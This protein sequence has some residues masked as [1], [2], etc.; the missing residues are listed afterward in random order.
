MYSSFTCFSDLSYE[1]NLFSFA[2]NTSNTHS[3]KPCNVNLEFSFYF[4]FN[5]HDLATRIHSHI[6]AHQILSWS[7][8]RN[9]LARFWPRSVLVSRFLKPWKIPNQYALQQVHSVVRRY[10]FLCNTISETHCLPNLL[11]SICSYYG[12]CVYLDCR[13]SHF[14]LK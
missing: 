8:A 2:T 13:F 7:L 10:S 9:G 6:Y 3:I 1:R 14:L 4:F 12:N 11:F 5:I